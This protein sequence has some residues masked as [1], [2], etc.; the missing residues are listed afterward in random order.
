MKLSKAFGVAIPFH[1]VECA[2]HHGFPSRSL[3]Y[4]RNRLR[5]DFLDEALRCSLSFVGKAD[6]RNHCGSNKSGYESF[7]VCCTSNA[8]SVLRFAVCHTALSFF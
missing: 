7:I 6:G 4:L 5:N 3:N 2:V 8:L 1:P